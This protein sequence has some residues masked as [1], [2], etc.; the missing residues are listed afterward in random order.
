MRKH[1]RDHIYAARIEFR[2]AKE[3]RKTI[4]VYIHCT[5]RENTAKINLEFPMY[6]KEAELCWVGYYRRQERFRY[7]DFNNQILPIQPLGE[8]LESLVLEAFSR[9]D[10]RKQ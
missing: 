2:I 8:K 10:N 6:M 3:G 1:P 4:S 9:I 7:S 5:K